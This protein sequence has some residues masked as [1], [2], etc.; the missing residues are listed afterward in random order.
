M[1]YKTFN[2]EHLG[3]QT[4]IFIRLDELDP[5]ETERYKLKLVYFNA[6]GLIEDM[7]ERSYWIDDEK[8]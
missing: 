6:D 4:L 5:D 2:N 8:K 7:E 1:D 3:R